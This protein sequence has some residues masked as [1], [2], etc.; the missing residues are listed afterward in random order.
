M[1]KFWQIAKYEYT[2]HVFRKRFIFALLSMPFFIGLLAAIII[3]MGIFMTDRSPVG[4]VDHTGILEN[5]LTEGNPKDLFEPGLEMVAFNSL[6]SALDSLETKD[7]QAVFILTETYQEDY[8]V[9]LYFYDQPDGNATTQIFRFVRKNLLVGEE[10]PNLERVTQGTTFLLLSQ[11]G[12]KSFEENEWYNVLPPIVISILFL[13]VVMTSGGYLLQA[14]VEEKENRTMEIVITSVSP[15]QLMAGKIVGNISVGL[16]QLLVWLVFGWLGLIIA[17]QFI[18]VLS[19]LDIS[20][21]LIIKS[22]LVILPAFVSV[23]AM[24][25]A[26]GATVTDSR[27]AQQVSGLFTLPIMVPL[28][29][30]SSIVMNPNGIIPIFLSYFPLS[31][32]ITLSLRSS[33]TVIPISEWIVIMIIQVVFAAFMV[34]LAGRAFRMGML[35]YGK[36]IS[37]KQLF[38]K[39]APYE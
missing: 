26:L 19:S 35:Q 6:E 5:P 29:F 22:A 36:R 31:S 10:I 34:W 14:V 30:I 20:I 28:W 27:E 39:E 33:F 38:R 25:A 15:F 16:T 2:R 12:S 13:M 3:L 8:V 37:L 9:P 24:M 21:G 4:Y 18:P 17:S 1:E 11:D 7:I 32:P 23:A